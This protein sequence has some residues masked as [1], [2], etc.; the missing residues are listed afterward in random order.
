MNVFF[1][2]LCLLGGD[3]FR[4]VDKLAEAGADHIELM[5][6]GP[7]WDSLRGR[8][9]AAAAELKKRPVGYSVHAPVWD[10]NLTCEN[11]SIRRG[12][13]ESYREAV[14]FAARLDAAHVVLHPGFCR[15]K[16]FDRSLAK[17]RAKEAVW[18][19]SRFNRDYGMRLLIENV[20]NRAS[21][22]FTLEEY[23]D[24]TR[25]FPDEVGCVVDVGHAHMNGWDIP[26]LIH[27]VQD[28]LYA[29]HLHDNDG[30][31][32]QHLPVGEGSIDWRS[33]F[34]ALE[35]VGRDVNLVLEYNTG[36]PLAKLKD[37]K[38]RLQRKK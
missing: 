17:E 20:G 36:M 33:V 38:D 18:Q 3:V 22:L 26:E 21:S 35:Q 14:A 28:R 29:L 16:T 5:L 37:Q 30:K 24:F 2:E 10:A 19:L 34:G 12:V 8:M 1:S 27:R 7:G 13:L 9:D 32:D 6:D 23:A 11:E 4:N 15:Q 31:S 25:D